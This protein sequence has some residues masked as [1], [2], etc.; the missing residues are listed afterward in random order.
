MANPS[1]TVIGSYLSPCVRK[2]L[3]CLQSKG[4]HC[5]VDPIVPFSGDDRIALLGPLWRVPLPTSD[6]VARARRSRGSARRGA[7]PARRWP[8]TASATGRRD[9]A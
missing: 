4:L 8:S 9:A 3:A 1:V 2:V 6:P 5:A 7:R